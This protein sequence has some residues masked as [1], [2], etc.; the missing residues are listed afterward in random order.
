MFLRRDENAPARFFAYN[1]TRNMF[2]LCPFTE[3]QAKKKPLFILSDSPP[4]MVK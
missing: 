1:F 4:F 3:M 2:K